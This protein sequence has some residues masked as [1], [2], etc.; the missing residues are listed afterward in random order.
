MA[1]CRKER[2]TGFAV[3][4]CSRGDAS[5]CSHES[6]MTTAHRLE[7][8]HHTWV[9]HT[10]TGIYSSTRHLCENAALVIHLTL[11]IAVYMYS[12]CMN[13]QAESTP[14]TSSVHVKRAVMNFRP[15]CEDVCLCT[16]PYNFFHCLYH[17]WQWARCN[18]TSLGPSDGLWAA[19]SA[20]IHT[21]VPTNHH[22]I[23]HVSMVSLL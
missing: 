4:V 12:T 11:H 23:A 8:I 21:T 19:A 3:P 7:S 15:V 22:R 20:G 14:K 10:L 17:H 18:L 1:S 6:T 2:W 16:L 5:V 9:T 13:I